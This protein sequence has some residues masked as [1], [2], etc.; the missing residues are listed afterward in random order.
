MQAHKSR[1]SDSANSFKVYKQ[2]LRSLLST[3]YPLLSHVILLFT[4]FSDDASLF[5]M[6][7][8]KEC[9]LNRSVLFCKTTT[10]VALKYAGDF[11]L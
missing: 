9:S 8:K 2:P 1:T 3:L 4:N 5:L 6:L 7:F 10:S 11:S